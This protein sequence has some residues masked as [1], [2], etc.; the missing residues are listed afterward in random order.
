MSPDE[1]NKMMFDY[2]GSQAPMLAQK[3]AGL[4]SDIGNRFGPGRMGG[5]AKS[6]ANVIDVPAMHAESNFAANLWK[7]N[8]ESRKFG[9]QGAS[10]MNTRT[11]ELMQGWAGTEAQY[12]LARRQMDLQRELNEKDWGDY[13]DDFMPDNV[14]FISE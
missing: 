8:L 13:M 11:M 10:N 2:R 1:M 12:D 6:V 4:Y 5:A 9:L 14:S 3:K 7:T